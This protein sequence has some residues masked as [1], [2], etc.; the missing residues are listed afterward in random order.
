MTK[1]VMLGRDH[2]SRAFWNA[3]LMSLLTNNYITASLSNVTI[4]NCANTAVTLSGNWT[5]EVSNCVFRKN[6]GTTGQQG[7]A[8]RAIN[9]GS[10]L[11]VMNWYKSCSC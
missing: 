2:R 11:T 5:F 7:G 10:F 4:Q 6:N 3:M 1:T 9:S 8:I